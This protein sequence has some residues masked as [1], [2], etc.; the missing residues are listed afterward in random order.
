MSGLVNGGIRR[1]FKQNPN[2]DSVLEMANS[3]NDKL[4]EVILNLQN[5]FNRPQ[6]E[7]SLEL[8]TGT[9]DIVSKLTLKLEDIKGEISRLPEAFVKINLF[10]E[11]IAQKEIK[12][13]EFPKFPELKIPETQKV[14]GE[15]KV[16]NQIDFENINQKLEELNKSIKSIKFPEQ[17]FENKQILKLLMELKSAIENIKF[18]EVKIPEVTI[19]NEIKVSNFPVQKYPM[20]VTHISINSMAGEVKT[21]SVTVT[22]ALTPLPEEALSNRRSVIIYNNSDVTVEVGGSTFT[23]GEGLPIPSGTFSPPLDAG[24]RMI[25]YGRIASG[26]AN[27]RVMEVSDLNIG[28]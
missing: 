18:P 8:D 23:F 26:S 20:P 17:K 13:P 3:L 25:V 2:K 1:Y 19:P 21:R 5:L 10:L 4:D 14:T 27:V 11:Q 9:G 15:V 7:T 24:S 12:I 22:S 28:R 6:G 16:T